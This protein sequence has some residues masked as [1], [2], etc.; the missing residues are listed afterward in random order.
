[1]QHSIAEIAQVLQARFEGAGE[2]TV[3]GAAEPALAGPFDLAMCMDPRYAEGL[4]KGRARAAILW[5]GADWQAMGLQAAIFAPRGRL[6]MA[7]LTQAFDPGPGLNP[8]ISPHA[9]IDPSAEIGEGASIGPFTVIGRNARIGARAR[10]AEQVSIGVDVT[11]GDDAL[12]LPG[13]K[14][15]ARV[16]IGH[17][18]VAQ[19]GAAIGGDGFSFV[20]EERS[21]V[22]EA[23]ATL[24]RPGETKK[25]AW[26]RIHSLGAVTIGDDVE[27]GAN[28]SLDRGTIRDTRI[29]RGTKID[30]LV[31]V[32]H[33]VVVGEDCLLCAQ[34]GV[35]GSTRVGDRVV[36]GGQVGVVDNIFVG[37]DVVVGGG[38]VVNSN[39]PAGRVLMGSPAVRMDLHVDIYKAQRRLPRMLAQI[40]ELQKTV[41]NLLE[42]GGHDA[43]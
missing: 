27:V 3:T 1:M 31:Q 34:V 22:E 43:P 5:E 37:D 41:K 40:A 28:A 38:S 20:T 14:I 39:A 35:G 4:S 25:Q 15:G 21:R 29:G 18:F 30:S 17:R 16:T 2:L 26:Q 7:R 13:V 42:K 36:L 12:I 11:I 8:G 10:I 23:R 9:V 32:G 33:N 19:P 6:A 24:G